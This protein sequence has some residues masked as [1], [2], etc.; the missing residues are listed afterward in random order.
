MIRFNEVIDQALVESIAAY[1]HAVET[2]RKTVLGVLGHDLRTPLGA[3]ML[4]AERLKQTKD[5][6]SRG[7][8]IIAQISSSVQSANQMV[9]DL[10]DLARCNLGT[11]IQVRP[12]N[13]DLIAVCK[14]VVDELAVVAP[15]A[16]IIFNDTACVIGQYDSSR[17]ARCSL[18]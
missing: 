6:G 4:G 2:T 10:L 7:K 8:K 12:E 16:Q 15:K 1:G 3:V 9:N 13:T 18:I 14:A 17:M 11:G 5:L